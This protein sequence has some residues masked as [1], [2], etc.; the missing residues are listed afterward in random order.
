MHVHI[1]KYEKFAFEY[2]GWKVSDNYLYNENS[3]LH[4]QYSIT[5]TSPDITTQEE[6]SNNSVRGKEIADIIT[7]LIPISGLPS[8]NSPKFISFSNNMKFVA[9]NPEYNHENMVKYL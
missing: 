1:N 4:S 8:L 2:L 5:I 7:V 6:L 9:L 3:P